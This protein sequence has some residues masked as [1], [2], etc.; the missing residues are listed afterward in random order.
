MGLGEKVCVPLFPLY[1]LVFSR[2][3]YP[4][5]EKGYMRILFAILLLTNVCFCEIDKG[6]GCHQAAETQCTKWDGLYAEFP[7]ILK[8]P[9]RSLKGTIRDVPGETLGGVLIE[10]Y[11][12]R[13]G[14][15]LDMPCK[16]RILACITDKTGRY[17]FNLPS[18]R[19]EI[20]ASKAGFTPIR[21][22]VTIKPNGGKK[23]DT[24]IKL[25]VAI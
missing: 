21:L 2:P 4:G 13:N 8:T 6:C 20:R 15:T 5:I 18:G 7:G 12:F 24:D 25:P 16:E 10:V 19:Y 1:S 22:S 9:L 3:A 17:S 23:K 11:P 14:N